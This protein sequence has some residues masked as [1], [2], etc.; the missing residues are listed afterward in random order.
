MAGIKIN[1]I[2]KNHFFFLLG[3][4]VL[5]KAFKASLN[6]TPL[7]FGIITGSFVFFRFARFDLATISLSAPR[8]VRGFWF[9]EMINLFANSVP[10]NHLL[11]GQS[12]SS[13]Q[14]NGGF[15]PFTVC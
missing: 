11:V 5:S 9:Y 7:R 6:E 4:G 8:H 13:R 15:H 3:G 1:C 12:L 2:S 14:A 10:S